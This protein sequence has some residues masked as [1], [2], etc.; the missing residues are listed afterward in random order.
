MAEEATPQTETDQQAEATGEDRPEE[1]LRAEMERRRKK[2]EKETEELRLQLQELQDKD[3]SEAERLR[4]RAERA[5]A[6]LGQVLGKVTS[7]EKGAWVRSAAAELNFHDPEDAVS[8]LGERLAAFEDQG[9]A[10]RAVKQ[11]AK[12]KKHLI[13]EDKPEQRP[14]IG[15]MFAGDQVPAQQ[16]GGQQQ[17]TPQQAA[18]E[19]ELAFAQGLAGELNRFRDGWHQAGGIA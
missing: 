6:Q 5:E 9:D 4:A 18:A 8:H 19:R 2:H 14:T 11:L 12:S 7:L 17:R 3:K 1:N 15:Q 10:K 16:A 13:R